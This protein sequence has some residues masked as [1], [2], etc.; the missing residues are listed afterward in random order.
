VLRTEYNNS[1]LQKKI[2]QPKRVIYP[3]PLFGYADV[4]SPHHLLIFTNVTLLA[5]ALGAGD[6]YSYKRGFHC[7]ICHL[8][9][10]KLQ[11]RWGMVCDSSISSIYSE[12]VKCL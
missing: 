10:I 8:A 6:L 12:P 3:Y 2:F 1:A 11:G 4:Y 7:A 5:A 9:G